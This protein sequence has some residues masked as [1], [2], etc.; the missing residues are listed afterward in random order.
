MAGPIDDDPPIEGLEP[1]FDPQHVAVLKAQR[2][3]WM[4]LAGGLRR[5]WMTIGLLVV[6]GIAHLLSGLVAFSQG[7]VNLA[8]AVSY[9]HLTLPTIYSV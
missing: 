7:Q 4:N 9:T 1:G 6:I 5:P 8:G 2:R 3:V